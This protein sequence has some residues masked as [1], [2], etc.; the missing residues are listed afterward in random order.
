MIGSSLPQ[1][2]NDAFLVTRISLSSVVLCDR[3]SSHNR[4]IQSGTIQRRLAWALPK[5]DTEIPE[6]FQIFKN[7]K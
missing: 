4:Y 1:Q 6:A 2:A 3:V 7:L 5:D